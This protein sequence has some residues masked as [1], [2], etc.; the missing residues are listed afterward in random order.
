MPQLL[1]VISL[2]AVPGRRRQTLD[3]A[4]EIE[5]R[6]F[7]GVYIPSR[8]GNMAQ[9]TALTVATRRISCKS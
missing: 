2:V 8:F 6:V 9:S 1:P 3:I 4:R 7:A 5:R